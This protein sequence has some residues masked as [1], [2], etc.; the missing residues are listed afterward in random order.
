MDVPWRGAKNEQAVRREAHKWS[1][2]MHG[3]DAGVHREA[4]ERWRAADPLHAEIY[5]RLEQ[6]WNTA[7]LL[8]QTPMARSRSPL[9]RRTRFRPHMRYAI[10]ATILILGV[11][12]MLAWGRPYW[13]DRKSQSEAAQMA[14]RIGE[15]RNIR[16]ADGSTVTLDTDSAIRLAFTPSERRLFLVRGRA[17]FDVAHNSGRP[18]IVAAGSGSVV[19]RGTLF[20]VSIIDGRV[21]V[22]LLRGSVDVRHQSDATH[23]PTANVARLAPGQATVFTAR[24]PLAPPRAAPRDQLDWTSGM[25]S[26]E[27]VRI[28]DAIS[29]AN[30]YS[31]AKI[32]VADPAIN[33]LRITGAYRAGDTRDLARSLAASFDLRVTNSPSGD[34]IIERSAS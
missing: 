23:A 21:R 14:S 16:L 34:I 31:T 30:R 1:M 20:D 13:A 18:F 11:T 10:A 4:F 15:I 8:A 6:H 24:T 9:E 5:A 27:A 28:S 19:A 32:R 3:D 33:E 2:R 29:E 7:G 12:A 25:L 26:F 17:R 22:A